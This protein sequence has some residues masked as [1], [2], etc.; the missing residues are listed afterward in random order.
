LAWISVPMIPTAGQ[1]GYCWQSS[2]WVFGFEAQGD[3]ASLEGSTQNQ[4][5]PLNRI[6][7][8]IDA[9]G[10]FTGQIGYAWDRTLLYV[11]GGAY[12]I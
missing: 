6:G 4:F 7:S 9:F 2:A 1:I 3:W 8:R 10:L 12:G 5:N 11:K